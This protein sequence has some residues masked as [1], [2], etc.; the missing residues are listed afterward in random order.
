MNRVVKGLAA[1]LAVPQVAVAFD[2]DMTLAEKNRAF[3]SYVV[4]D[5]TV[6]DSAYVGVFAFCWESNSLMLSGSYPIK[7]KDDYDAD[8]LIERAPGGTFTG[9]VILKEPLKSEDIE[10]V[11]DDL[12]EVGECSLI[13]AWEVA[14]EL[15]F[16]V[17]ELDNAKSVAE[18]IA[19]LKELEKVQ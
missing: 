8:V 17:T 18:L 2:L 11:V 3:G 1:L 16:P 12:Y 6:G 19:K 7:S 15:F 13:G 5:L 9:K 14:S 4:E 10:R